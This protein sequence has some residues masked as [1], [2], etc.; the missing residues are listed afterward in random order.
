MITH[1]HATLASGGGLDLTGWARPTRHTQK[2]FNDLTLYHSSS[3]LGLL[4]ARDDLCP[5]CGQ[6]VGGLCKRCA[7]ELGIKDEEE[8]D[9]KYWNSPAEATVPSAG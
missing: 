2:A 1:F 6:W 5:E 7:D 4:G 8:F 9:T 3:F